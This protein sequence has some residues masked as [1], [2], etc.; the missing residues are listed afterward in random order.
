MRVHT[1]HPRCSRWACR[2]YDAAVRLYPQEFRRAFGQELAVTFRNSVDDVLDS[3]SIGNWLAF[4][5]HI[6]VDFVCTYCTLLTESRAD[7]SMSILGLADGDAACGGLDQ[8]LVDASLIFAIAGL[9]LA[10]V[11]WY[12]YVAVLPRYFA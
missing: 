12:T 8:A 7:A 9:V 2:L 6:A 11:G 5:A 1:R 10:F 4:A 3:D